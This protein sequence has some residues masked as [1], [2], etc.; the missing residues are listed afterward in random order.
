M[1]PKNTP[2]LKEKYINEV[3]P[4]MMKMFAYKNRMQV[5]KLSKVTV[6]MG[7]GAAKD[8]IKILDK[9]MDELS[10][11]T[12]QRPVVC[13][14]KKAISNFKIREDQAIG[15]KV[16]LRAAYMYEFLDRL[17]N[18]ALPRIRDFRGVPGTSFD[19]DGNYSM[20]LK[21]QAIFPEIDYD[22]ASQRVQGMNITIITTAKT[23]N[24]SHELLRLLGMP[25]KAKGEE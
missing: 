2:R 16:T 23:G 21:E 6:S 7:V 10:L 14:S 17:M 15:C 18:I 4:E 8:D 22:K 13:R 11:I 5:P 25:F 19:Q 24:E 3:V 1:K 20:G 12:G 9:A